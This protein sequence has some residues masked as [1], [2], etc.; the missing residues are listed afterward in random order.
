MALRPATE[1]EHRREDIAIGANPFMVCVKRYPKSLE[2]AEPTMDVWLT[3][4]A[5]VAFGME[6]KKKEGRK[7]VEIP[8]NSSINQ[9][10]DLLSNLKE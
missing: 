4:A 2:C 6:Q 5:G 8:G 7:K 9:I 1:F 3:F 10:G